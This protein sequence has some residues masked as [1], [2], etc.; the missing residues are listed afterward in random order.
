MSRIV[1]AVDLSVPLPTAIMPARHSLHSAGR[2]VDISWQ[3]V[4]KTDANKV[5]EAAKAAGLS[6]GGDFSKPDPVHFYPDPG[7]DRRQ[8]VD[9][10]SRAVAA[11]RG[12]IPDR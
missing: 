7:A 1:D 4:N 6:W 12:E 3:G 10:F 9:N 2:G 8:L 11:S 5:L